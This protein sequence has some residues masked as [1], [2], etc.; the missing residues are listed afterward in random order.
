MP[1]LGDEEAK[2][3]DVRRP[4]SPGVRTCVPSLP[5]GQRAAGTWPQAPPQTTRPHELPAWMGSTR[6]AVPTPECGPIFALFSFGEKRQKTLFQAKDGVR[7]CQAPHPAAH[8]PG[9]RTD[10]HKPVPVV[11]D[12]L[13]ILSSDPDNLEPLRRKPGGQTSTPVPVVGLALDIVEEL[14]LLDGA[15]HGAHP[16][17]EPPAWMS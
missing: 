8:H 9:G 4:P 6:G 14:D 10:T 5:H 3:R 16:R 11:E 15:R 1:P 17:P 2:P 13:L 12:P 7:G